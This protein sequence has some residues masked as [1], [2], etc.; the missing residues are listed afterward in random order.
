MLHT[1]DG[2]DLI[3][4]FLVLEDVNCWERSPLPVGQLIHVRGL[5]DRVEGII[6]AHAVYIAGV[7]RGIGDV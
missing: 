3:L 1:I 6:L 4:V 2:P 5:E 7:V